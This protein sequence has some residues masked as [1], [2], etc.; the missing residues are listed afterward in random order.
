MIFPSDA[1][2]REYAA[3]YIRAIK[4]FRQKFKVEMGREP[5]EFEV[6]DFAKMGIV[7]FG[8]LKQNEN[9]YLQASQAQTPAQELENQS[10][11]DIVKGHPELSIEGDIIVMKRWI[12]P[13]EV[14]YKVRD[15]LEKRN[16]RYVAH[17]Y[18]GG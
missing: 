12:K 1:E 5:S 9:M 11:I 13:T 6:Q 10:V 4:I 16:W 18:A 8:I 15:E 14:F 2:I 17:R 7:P 3:Y